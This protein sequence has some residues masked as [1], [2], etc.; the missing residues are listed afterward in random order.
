MD[1]GVPSKQCL[2]DCVEAQ[3]NDEATNTI[4]L[5]KCYARCSARCGSAGRSKES[6]ANP[7]AVA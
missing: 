4:R 1:R 5:S 3:V 7:P 2:G 6:G